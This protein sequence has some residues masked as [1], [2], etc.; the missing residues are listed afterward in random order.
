METLLR[1]EY[2]AAAAVIQE[3]ITLKPQLGLILGSGLGELADRVENATI[4]PYEEIPNYP[5]GSVVGHVG[6]LVVGTIEGQSVLVMQGRTHFYEGITMQQVGFPVRVMQM[7]GIHTLIVTNAAGGLN[8][9]FKAGE[10]MLIKDHI[11]L[12]AMAGQNPL[13]GKNDDSLGPRFTPMTRPYDKTLRDL[14]L[15]VAQSENITLHQGVY[16][17]LSGPAFETPAEI[18]M[19]RLWG[20]DAV[21]MSTAPEVMVARHAGM[22]VLGFSSITNE[23]IDDVDSS[24]VVSHEEVLEVGKHIVPNLIRLLQGVLRQIS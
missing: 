18:R 15:Q 9:A 3:R 2:E 5:M 8:P 21:G 17:N 24:A 13:M 10:L 16:V 4:I 14:A 22:R 23:A 1:K 12:P 19:L 7:L 6:R 20:G 11:S